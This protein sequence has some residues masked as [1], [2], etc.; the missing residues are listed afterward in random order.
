MV[1]SFS[2]ALLKVH[3]PFQ[4]KILSCAHVFVA[5]RFCFDCTRV[6]LLLLLLSQKRIERQLNIILHENVAS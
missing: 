6:E 5:S 3:F 1:C 4:L 2:N